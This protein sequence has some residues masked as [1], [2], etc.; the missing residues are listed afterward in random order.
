MVARERHAAD[1]VL[2]PLLV[3]ALLRPVSAR[4]ILGLVPTPTAEA[5]A[6]APPRVVW[7][8]RAAEFENFLS[9]C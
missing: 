2:E 3:G 7:C 9:P 5:A 8:H 4:I 6:Q 1:M